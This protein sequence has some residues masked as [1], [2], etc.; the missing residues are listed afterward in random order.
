MQG[1]VWG[2]GYPWTV[3]RERKQRS[4]STL[5]SH[6][7]VHQRHSSGGRGRQDNQHRNRQWWTVAGRS[8]AAA[9]RVL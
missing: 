4:H 9:G 1:R 2:L 3:R 5:G 8:A 6:N 7:G